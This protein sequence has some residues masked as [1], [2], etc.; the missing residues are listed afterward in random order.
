MD[1]SSEQIANLTKGEDEEMDAMAR[2]CWNKEK[3][4]LYHVK[5][6]LYGRSKNKLLKIVEALAFLD[7]EKS[8]S[9]YFV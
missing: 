4:G 8:G 5:V 7:R 1:A 2:F 3:L 6:Y 9:K